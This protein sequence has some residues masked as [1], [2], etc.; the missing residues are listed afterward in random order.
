MPNQS[1]FI[2]HNRIKVPRFNEDAGFVTSKLRSKTM[3]KIRAKNSVPEMML[4]KAL[5][6]NNFRFRI[7]R[8]DLP[9]KPDVAID[10]YHL[11]IFVDGVTNG[12]K[13]NRKQTNHF[14]FPR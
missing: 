6:A 14:G 5:W 10:K 11:A 13:E 4:R 8:K 1:R 9:G 12:K 3:S 2:E 7:H